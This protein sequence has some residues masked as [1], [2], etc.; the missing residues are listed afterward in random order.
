ML[1]CLLAVVIGGMGTMYGAV[2]GSVLWVLAKN[3]LQDLIK[4]G[5]LAADGVPLSGPLLGPLV[6]R[7][8]LLPWWGLLSVLSALSVYHVPTGVVGRLRALA[9]RQRG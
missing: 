1:D 8:R 5:A 9:L 4:L 3:D 6:S 2:I 7:R